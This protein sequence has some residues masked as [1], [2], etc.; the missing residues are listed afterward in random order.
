MDAFWDQK[1]QKQS[2]NSIPIHT[3]IPTC[4]GP[5]CV[6]APPSSPGPVGKFPGTEGSLAVDSRNSTRDDSLFSSS[7]SLKATAQRHT[8]PKLRMKNTNLTSE[9]KCK[10][11]THNTNTIHESNIR[12]Q[13]TTRTISNYESKIRIQHKSSVRK[14]KQVQHTNNWE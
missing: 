13:Q 6:A 12:I 10:I 1:E 3:N 5:S 8:K 2:L 7:V 4:W 11:R 9:S 14:K